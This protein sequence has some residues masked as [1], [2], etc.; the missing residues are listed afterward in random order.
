[1]CRSGFFK[2]VGDDLYQITPNGIDEI[3]HSVSRF[4][5]HRENVLGK[6]YM[7]SVQQRLRAASPPLFT[8]DIESRSSEDKILDEMYSKFVQEMDRERELREKREIRRKSRAKD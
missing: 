1:M 5:L 8:G 2:K 6:K 3:F 7:A 4:R